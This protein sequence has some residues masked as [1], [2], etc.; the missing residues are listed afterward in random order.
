MSII[1]IVTD[2]NK[3]IE[4]EYNLK[5]FMD[6]RLKAV[7]DGSL[8][9]VSIKNDKYYYQRVYMNG[10]RKSIILDPLEDM[11]R[12]VIKELM[13]KKTI[14]HGLPILRNNIKAM[15]K[16]V[17]KLK[18]YD[19]LDF[20]Y[21]ELL[22]KDYYLDD[23]VCVR[24]WEKK[25]DRQNPYHR[26]RLIHETKC[27]IKV[28]SKSEMLIADT[29]FDH[30]LEYKNETKLR[31][32]G[33]NYYPDF[34]ILHPKTRRIIWWEHLGKLADPGYVFE[35]L[36]RIVVF[37]RNGIVVGDN[38]ILTWETQEMPLTHAMVDQRLREFGLI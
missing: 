27:G 15:E 3:E 22:G 28:R 20:K 7:P 9:A 18:P 34:E 37:G 12:E 17:S 32:E 26:E 23:D 35:N 29:L 2:L 19:P 6:E 21:G 8:S 5:A 31:L 16:C 25:P 14:V 36:D 24:E 30:G 1:S 13:E 4:R 33:R 10:S 38:L 11:H